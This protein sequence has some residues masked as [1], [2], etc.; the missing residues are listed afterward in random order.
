[1]KLTEIQKGMEFLILSLAGS[2]FAGH[3]ARV[4]EVVGERIF[5]KTVEGEFSINVHPGHV[6]FWLEVEGRGAWVPTSGFYR[7]ENN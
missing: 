2:H 7:D 3:Y 6:I 1:M 5:G 4:T